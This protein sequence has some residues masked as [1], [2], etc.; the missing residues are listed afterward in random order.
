MMKLSKN[1]SLKELTR[2]QTAMRL[3]IENK[4]NQEQLVNLT[5]LTCMVLQKIRE[6]HG[7]VNVNSA[8]RVL[9]LNRAIG[10]GDSS[11]HIQGKAADIEC[12]SIDNLE[13]AK[14]IKDNISSYDQLILEFYEPGIPDSGWIHISYSADGNNRKAELTASRVDGKVQYTEGING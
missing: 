6:G 5:A 11:Q 4:P 1:F 8:L 7:R 10:S 14:W 2:S 13:L 9:E 12:P 3:G